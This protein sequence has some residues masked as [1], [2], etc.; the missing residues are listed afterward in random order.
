MTTHPKKRSE[1]HFL[2]TYGPAMAI[3]AIVAM[4]LTDSWGI[5]GM[6]FT[7]TRRAIYRW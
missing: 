4:L 6:L 5:T 2:R 3:G 1:N 7:V